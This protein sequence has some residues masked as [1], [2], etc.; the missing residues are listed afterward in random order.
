MQRICLKRAGLTHSCNCA[1]T[2]IHEQLQK[3]ISKQIQN[4]K[5]DIGMWRA[6]HELFQSEPYDASNVDESKLFNDDLNGSGHDLRPWTSKEVNNTSGN[7]QLHFCK[8]INEMAR[9]ED[10]L[11]FLKGDAVCILHCL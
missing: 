10:E 6:W 4:V 11:D 2:A 5:E 9:T 1:A 8:I 3:R 7:F